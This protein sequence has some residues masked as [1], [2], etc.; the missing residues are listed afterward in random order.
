LIGISIYVF[1]FD[2]IF[3]IQLEEHYRTSKMD[4]IITLIF[5]I[6]TYTVNTSSEGIYLVELNLAN[7][8]AE[9]VRTI[10]ATNPSFLEYTGENAMLYYVEEVGNKAGTVNAARVDFTDL[11][12]EKKSSFMTQGSAPCHL[13]ISPDQQTLIASNYSS[14]NF[15]TFKLAPEGEIESE[16]SNYAFNAHSV[17]PTRQKQSHVH[18]AFYTPDGNNVFVQD[19]GGDGIYQFKASQITKNGQSYVTHQMPKGSGPRHL[20]LSSTNEFVYI[21][22]ELN[23]TIDVYGLDENGF[24]KNHV[25]N[26]S[27]D[28]TD[29][30]NLCA[31]IRLSSDGRFLYASNRGTKNSLA[32]YVVG[33]DGKLALVQT[34]S[35]GGDGPRH[36][37]FTP[38]GDFMLVANQYTNN[39]SI[40]RRDKQNGQLS[41]MDLEIKVPAPVC[42]V[43]L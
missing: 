18:S 31:H 16:T 22:N 35:S 21:I 41:K 1:N 27:T 10:S 30:D 43:S 9:I 19:L 25:Q 2:L 23:G 36:F 28:T 37:E 32:V 8:S 29:G 15:T 11:S 26:I 33:P 20:A 42:I 34:I 13:A 3:E 24:V 12:V 39:V 14:G 38:D 5:A 7:K 6:G 4:S 40:F 17:H